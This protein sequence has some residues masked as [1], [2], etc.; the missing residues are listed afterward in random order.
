MF[1]KHEARSTDPPQ[2]EGHGKMSEGVRGVD[3]E[4]VE[5]LET[6]CLLRLRLLD[7]RHNWGN[8]KRVALSD[9]GKYAGVC[10]CVCVCVCVWR[11]H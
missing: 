4:Y 8:V 6:Y 2:D 11:V 10:V 9:H 5:L 7:V 1:L 3:G